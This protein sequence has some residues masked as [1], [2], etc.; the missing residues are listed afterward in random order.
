MCNNIN[1][2]PLPAPRLCSG[3]ITGIIGG[4]GAHD[5]LSGLV[6]VIIIKT[7]HT[8]HIGNILRHILRLDLNCNDVY[9]EY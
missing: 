7:L 8:F 5:V 4:A 6:V 1:I 3:H 9:I 2:W